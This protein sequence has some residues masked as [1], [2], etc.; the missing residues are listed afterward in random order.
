L[1]H[2]THI[3]KNSQMTSTH[4]QLKIFAIFKIKFK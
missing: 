1:N 3:L 2:P 4:S